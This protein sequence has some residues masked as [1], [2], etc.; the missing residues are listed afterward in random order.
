LLSFAFESYHEPQLRLAGEGVMR[1]AAILVLP[2]ELERAAGRLQASA[3]QVRSVV[4]SLVPATGGVGAGL[5]DAALAERFQA[6][7]SRWASELGV[8]ADDLAGAAG[9]LQA[10]AAEYRSTDRSAIP[11]GP[12]HAR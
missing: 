10:A 6:M 3:D 12:H 5:G 11:P 1:M 4:G 9:R 2:G 8:I 7:W